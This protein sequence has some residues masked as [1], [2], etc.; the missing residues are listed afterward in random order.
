MPVSQQLAQLFGRRRFN[1]KPG[2]ERI[3]ALLER[4]GH[5]ERSF[6][7]VHIVGT[8]GKGSTAAFLASIFEQA[9][10]NTGLFTSP[11]LVSYTERFRINGVDISSEQLGKLIQELLDLATPDDTFFELT[12]ALACHWFAQNNIQI[13][14]L[15]AGMGG[16]SDATAAVPG[17]A[18]IITPIALDHCQWL[19]TDLQTI[20]AE[21]V[22]IAAPGSPI[23]SAAQAPEVLNVLEEYCL[24]NGNR[25]LLAERDFNATCNGA[26]GSLSYQGSTGTVSGLF[27]SLN[28][29]Y[30]I[31][32]ATLALAA[33]EQLS[34]QGFPVVPQAMQQGLA[35][36]RWPGRMELI[37]LP[38]GVELLLDG[39]HN[40]AGALALAD[41]LAAYG[42]RKK[43]LLLGMME[44]KD[45][46]GV[47]Q[48][49]LQQ[50]QQVITVSPSQ[51]R[52]IPATDL[53]ASCRTEG[54]P[55]TAAGLV[56][57]GLEAAQ[58]AAK[59]GDLIIA[60]GSLFLVGELKALLAGTPCEA[61]RG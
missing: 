54:T 39:A 48:P 12:T 16:R 15:E 30:Q 37:R 17:L 55:A 2:L 53:A 58:A 9:G 27:P 14:V 60:A 26:D 50:V 34:S 25:L 33:A 45:L 10:F 7:A 3:T 11:H 20:A 23:I 18:T 57:A 49:L 22:G 43:I 29:R 31:G 42:T 40:P 4:H 44:D 32:N 52:A 8:N 47:L 6:A 46:H 38:D 61:V 36:T 5:P 35:S 56:A 13:A 1:I 19:G 59:P 28:G 41:A 24:L 21:K 51:E